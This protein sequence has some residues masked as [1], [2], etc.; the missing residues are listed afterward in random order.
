MSDNSYKIRNIDNLYDFWKR[1]GLN[2]KFLS[3]C[4]E[5]IED[6]YLSNLIQIY[7]YASFFNKK[8]L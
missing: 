8:I 2:K 7:L 3:F 1:F 4:I 6:S 5:L